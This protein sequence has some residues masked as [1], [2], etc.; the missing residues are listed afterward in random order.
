MCAAPYELGIGE[1]GSHVEE[2]E[3]VRSQHFVD[4]LNISSIAMHPA[5][6]IDLRLL[7]ECAELAEEPSLEEVG[8]PLRNGRAVGPD[9]I[10]SELLKLG[11]QEK[12]LILSS[13]QRIV[14]QVWCSEEVPHEW[15]VLPYKCYW[16][17]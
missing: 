3:G 16:N 7:S 12:S 2:V 14:C 13:I 1:E 6:A 4:L 8:E 17:T 15:Q 9:D 5:V 11:L 10:A